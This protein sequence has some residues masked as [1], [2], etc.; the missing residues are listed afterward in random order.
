MLHSLYRRYLAVVQSRPVR[1]VFGPTSEEEEP[2]FQACFSHSHP[3]R[4]GLV[5]APSL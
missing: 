4:L 2:R 3:L 1:L 5:W